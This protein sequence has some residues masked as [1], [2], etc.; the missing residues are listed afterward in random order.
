M[1]NFSGMRT[2]LIA[3]LWL[4]SIGAS[5][6]IINIEKKRLGS[7]ENGW[8]GNIDFHFKYTNNTRKIWEFGNRAAFQYHK[9]K[10]NYLFITDLKLIRKDHE[11]LINKGYGHFRYNHLFKDSGN[12][13]LEGFAQVQ[14][15]GVQKIKFRSLNGAGL[16]MK[17]LGNDTI[18]LNFGTAAM[19]EH[20]ENTL[21]SV[22]QDIRSSNYLSFNWKISAKLGFKTINYF[23][24]LFRQPDDYRF[25]NESSLSLSLTQKLSLTVT[26]NV[27]YDAY[28]VEGVPNTITSIHNAL[29]FKF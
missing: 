26:Y 6:Q 14:Y 19:F 3:T 9:D 10:N 5:A 25:S 16:R 18:N 21:E 12:V 8:H 22:T 20:E 11:D 24:P 1:S 29:R 27:L 23:Q 28:P 15:N 13:S 2:I 4:I 17:V 7:V